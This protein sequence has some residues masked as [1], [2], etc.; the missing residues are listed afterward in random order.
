VIS[1]VDST[2][3][4]EDGCIYV[5]FSRSAQYGISEADWEL[6]TSGVDEV[7][8]SFGR[9]RRRLVGDGVRSRARTRE[10]QGKLRAVESWVYEVVGGCS[11]VYAV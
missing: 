11:A 3:E 2:G 4:T 8:T 1:F 10:F 7:E 9:F 5:T 6:L